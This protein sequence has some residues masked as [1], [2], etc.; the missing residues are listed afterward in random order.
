MGQFT[1][2]LNSNEIFAALYNMI[3]SQQVFADNIKTGDDLVNDN[4]VDGTLYGDTKLYYATDVLSSSEWG[5]DAEAENLLQLH[6][7]EAPD[8]QSI[9]LDKFRQIALTTD[10]YLSKRAWADEGAFSSFNDVMKQWIQDTKKVYDATTFNC[11]FGT[12][13]TSVGNQDIKLTLSTIA[14]TG[15]EKARIRAQKIAHKVARTLKKAADYSRDYNDYQNLRN[16]DKSDLTIVWNSEYVD[17]ITN[18]DLPSLFHNDILSFSK[19]LEARYFGDVITTAGTSDGTKR[20]LIE[21]I[22]TDGTEKVHIFAGDLIPNK[23]KY[24]AYTAYT[25]NPKIICKIYKA[26]SIP[27]MSAFEVATNFFNAKSLTDNNY[28][29]WGHNTIEYLKNYPFITIEEN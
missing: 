15:E 21:Q 14:E 7:P 3:I 2:K 16:Y 17:E 25:E 22:V 12:A 6:R 29:T 5:N 11:Y 23:F 28:L 8:C 26:G 9:T 20:T 27:F 1:G 24:E 18:L 13:R 10:D 19:E 4:R